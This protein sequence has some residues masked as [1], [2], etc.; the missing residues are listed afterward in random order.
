LTPQ[1]QRQLGAVVAEVCGP[2]A[3]PLVVLRAAA[4]GDERARGWLQRFEASE[5]FNDVLRQG[6]PA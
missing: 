2:D 3:P 5:S 1:E 4:A 6:P